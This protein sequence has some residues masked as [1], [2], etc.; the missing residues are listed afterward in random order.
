[1]GAEESGI[2]QGKERQGRGRKAEKEIGKRGGVGGREP[3]AE[4]YAGYFP[5]ASSRSLSIYLHPALCPRRWT[6]MAV[7]K[8]APLL[9]L[10]FGFG[11]WGGWR[12]ERGRMES[13]VRIFITLA[14]F[15]ISLLR[16]GCVSHL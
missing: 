7:I 5:F 12:G 14:L 11:Q 15:P 2:R 10:P 13:E 1:M 16:L 4:N 9:W 6:Y 8:R 3:K